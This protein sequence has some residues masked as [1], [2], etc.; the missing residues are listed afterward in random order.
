MTAK[1]TITDEQKPFSAPILYTFRNGSGLKYRSRLEILGQ[2]D[3][4]WISRQGDRRDTDLKRG[5]YE[6][7]TKLPEPRKETCSVCGE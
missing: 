7:R 2:P 1:T 6:N 3:M 5:N 4:R